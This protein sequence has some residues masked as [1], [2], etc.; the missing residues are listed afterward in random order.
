MSLIIDGKE[1]SAKKHTITVNGITYELPARTGRLEKLLLQHDKNA[2]KLSEYESNKA[3]IELLLGEDAFAAIFPEGEDANLDH[4]STLA[5]YAVE[6]FNANQK[7]L[8]AEHINRQVAPIQPVVD[9][10]KQM[11]KRTKKRVPEA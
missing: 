5:Y 6:A 10:I 2:A 1:H 7:A 8:E 3:L 11:N 9:V 4:I